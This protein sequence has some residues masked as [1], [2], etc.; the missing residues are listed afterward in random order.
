[1]RQLLAVDFGAPLH[2]LVIGGTTHPIEEEMLNMY[3]LKVESI[4]HKDHR[5]A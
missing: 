1:M 5:T 4:D 2:C 3:K